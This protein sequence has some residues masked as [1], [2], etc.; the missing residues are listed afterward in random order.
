[1]SVEFED[2]SAP[3][4]AMI[5]GGL[6]D[7]CTISPIAEINKY[8]GLSVS[9]ITYLS[10]ISNIKLGTSDLKSHDI[11]SKS[12]QICFCT[13]NTHDDNCS[14]QPLPVNVTHGQEF[15]ISLVA[16]DQ[17]NHTVANVCIFSSME[18]NKNWLNR[19]QIVQN[20]N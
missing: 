7:R 19:G 15:T 17:V 8:F 4:G 1:M 11:R 16:V 14:H 9:G 3:S 13:G 2:N 10:L 12:V 20:T 5:F 18:S 6:L